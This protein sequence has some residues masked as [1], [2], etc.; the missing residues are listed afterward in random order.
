MKFPNMNLGNLLMNYSNLSFDT[1]GGKR[2]ERVVFTQR[3]ITELKKQFIAKKYLNVQE[4]EKLAT[5]IGL[6]PSQVWFYVPEN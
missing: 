2:K 4:R 1:F 6:K 3:Q 5:E